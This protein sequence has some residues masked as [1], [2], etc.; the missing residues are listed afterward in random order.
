MKL[1]ETGFITKTTY[2]KT[3]H[4]YFFET[5]TNICKYGQAY[6]KHEGTLEEL[7]DKYVK[8][9]YPMYEKDWDEK[10]IKRSKEA[11]SYLQKV[12]GYT[13]INQLTLG[14]IHAIKENADEGYPFDI[15]I[16]NEVK[17]YLGVN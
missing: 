8:A 1:S 13:D 3:K 5:K 2:K 14:E 4:G 10:E 6:L 7:T 11:L 12:W 16:I 17:K 9:Y 15:E